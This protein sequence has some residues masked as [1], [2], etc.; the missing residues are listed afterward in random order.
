LASVVFPT[1]RKGKRD[2]EGNRN[3]DI[4]DHYGNCTF[5]L[6]VTGKGY[7]HIFFTLKKDG[8][9]KEEWDEYKKLQKKICPIPHKTRTMQVF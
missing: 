2:K 6:S 8:K 4:K 1:F 5:D 7:F 3:I 9:I